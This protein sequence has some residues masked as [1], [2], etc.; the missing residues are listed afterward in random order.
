MV[1]KMQGGPA[2]EAAR[3]R[4]IQDLHPHTALHSGVD[5]GRRRAINGAAMTQRPGGDQGRHERYRERDSADPPQR[6][7]F[8]NSTVSGNSSPP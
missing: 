2:R 1:A 8:H 5:V 6:T 3:V 4:R 7:A